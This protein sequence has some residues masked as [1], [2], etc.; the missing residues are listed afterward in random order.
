MSPDVVQ[1]NYYGHADQLISLLHFHTLTDCVR[2]FYI[3]R[4]W[5]TVWD[6]S[7]AFSDTDCV[8]L[9]Y[10]I[11]RHWLAVWDCSTALSGTDWLC[12]IVLL[13]IQTLTDC[14][15]LVNFHT[16]TGGG[17]GGG[18][19]EGRDRRCTWYKYLL[20]CTCRLGVESR[21]FV[22]TFTGRFKSS[23]LPV[24]VWGSR[25]LADKSWLVFTLFCPSRSIFQRLYT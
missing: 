4:H 23:C 14:V 17:G 5:L 25:L 22:L 21:W 19:C 11:F 2:L 1:H 12:E 15:R 9:F 10:C 8:R 7:T 24:C 13:H 20:S 18:G 3:F 6:R 16:P